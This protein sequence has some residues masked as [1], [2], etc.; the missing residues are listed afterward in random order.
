MEEGRVVDGRGR[1]GRRGG[2]QE[3]RAREDGGGRGRGR[4]RGIGAR[5][6]GDVAFSVR[7]TVLSS[8][9]M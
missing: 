3:R 2:G 9:W 7:G 4:G 1:L 8:G 6:R 5:G